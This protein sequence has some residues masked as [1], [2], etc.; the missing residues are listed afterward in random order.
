MTSP[1]WMASPPEVHS[2]LLSSGAGPG[3]LLAAAGAWQS[4]SIEYASA[5]AELTS[6]LGEV[7]AGSWEGPSAEQYVVAHTPYLSWLTQTSADSAA[8]AARHEAVAAAYTTALATM[9]TLSELAA[10]HMIHGVLVGTNFFGINT[11]PLALNEADYVRM[12]VQAATTMDVYQGISSTI[13][14][15]IAPTTPPPPIMAPGAEMS[16]IAAD[17]S[18]LATQAQAA[19][20]GSALDSS[21]S[22]TDQLMNFFRD[23]LGTLIQIIGD[24]LR[25]PAAALA[26]WLPLLL[27]LG[28]LVYLVV[29]QGYWLAWAMIIATPIFVPLLIM[30][31]EQY[32]NPPA[33]D[34]APAG[35][36]QQGNRE[37][38]RAERPESL[39]AIALAPTGTAVPT[40][41]GSATPNPPASSSSATTAASAPPYL[42]YAA[43]EEPPAVRFG[44]TLNEGGKAQAQA[45]GISA[46]AAAAAPTR[47]GTRRKR[48]ARVKD[49]APQH[50]DM[51]ITVDAEFGDPARSEQR[52]RT[53]SARGSGPFG[54]AGTIPNTTT[55]AGLVSHENSSGSL[56]AMPML[57]TTWGAEADETQSP[58]ALDEK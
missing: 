24:F 31:V 38:V 20:S 37:P 42:V 36:D 43:R 29:S 12:W 5:A 25:N 27:T 10:N 53:A 16:R 17:T 47:S 13:V 40:A 33:T 22:V 44:P 23:P 45:S 56:S 39:S 46:W 28:V 3:S 58:P 19:E 50:M 6:L 21:N 54:L 51:N 1:I 30:A 34:E 48:G 57:P 11:I 14:T 7:G 2:A 52:K 32:L 15:S 8:T 49:P 55:A 35:A 41:A 26:T 18:E 9:P 4:L